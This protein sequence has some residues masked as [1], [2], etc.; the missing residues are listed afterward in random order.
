MQQLRH[1]KQQGGKVTGEAS[2]PAAN[3]HAPNA[4][5]PAACF[6]PQQR[7]S[8]MSS[9][10]LRHCLLDPPASIGPGLLQGTALV[11]IALLGLQF[12]VG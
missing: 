8:S 1:R 6:L 5:A 9:R 7:H 2:T 12:K 4:P 3:G 10:T 11:L